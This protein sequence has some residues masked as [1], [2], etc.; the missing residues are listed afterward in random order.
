MRIA[1]DEQPA[2]LLR[3]FCHATCRASVFCLRKGRKGGLDLH[4]H[5]QVDTMLQLKELRHGESRKH[6]VELLVVLLLQLSET[7]FTVQHLVCHCFGL[8]V[9][10]V[11]VLLG[12]LLYDGSATI[13]QQRSFVI[14]L[15]MDWP[16]GCALFV[17][18]IHSSCDEGSPVCLHIGPHY[19]DG[20][21]DGGLLILGT[22]KSAKCEHHE[23][24]D[25]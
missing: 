25:E 22:A 19:C 4:I 15:L 16:E 12:V 9:G 1:V 21:V 2:S 11:R 3:R 23:R 20:G 5:H 7:K 24:N 8:G 10:Q 13:I 14:V 18:E 6:S 17:V